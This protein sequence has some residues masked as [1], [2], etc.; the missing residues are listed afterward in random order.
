M[1]LQLNKI[2]EEKFD[3]TITD[4]ENNVIFNDQRYY[5]YMGEEIVNQD[6]INDTINQLSTLFGEF[7]EIENDFN[8]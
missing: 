5:N 1:K 2:S 6:N 8:I 7:T 4:I 3:V